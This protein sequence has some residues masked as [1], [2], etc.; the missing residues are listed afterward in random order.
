MNLIGK[1]SI[2]VLLFI[3]FFLFSKPVFG[4]EDVTSSWLETTPLPYTLASHTSIVFDNNILVIGGSAFTGQSRQGLIYSSSLQDG[5]L[6]PWISEGNFP[7]APIWQSTVKDGENIYVLGGREENPGSANDFVS[8]V[9]LGKVQDGELSSWTAQ[10]PLPK[11]LGMGASVISGNKIYFAGGFNN[12]ELSN[13]VYVATIESNGNLGAWTETTP[14][15]V[16]MHG[17]GM[18][19]HNNKVYIFGGYSGVYHSEV[20][21]AFV[22]PDGTLSSWLSE[23]SFPH[24]LYRQSVVK[25]GNQFFSI[26]GADSNGNSTKT[27]YYATINQDGSLAPWELS[28]NELPFSLH[29]ATAVVV[30]NHLYVMGGFQSGG[31]YVNSVY[32]TKLNI[33]PPET[34]LNVPLFMQNDSAWGNHI[35]DSANLWSPSSPGISAWG[36]AMSSAAMVFNYHKIT[37]L[38]N[39]LDLNP[40]N[41]NAW[42]KAQPD[43][44][45]GSGWVNWLALSRL[46]KQ[47][48]PRNPLFTYDALEFNRVIGNNHTQLKADLE[49]SIPGILE[50]PGHFVVGKGTLSDS[51]AINDPYYSDRTTLSFYSN[52]FITL[53]RFIPSNTDLSYIML[54]VDDGIMPLV[55]D[56]GGNI[57]GEGFIQQPLDE[58]EG[59]R[60]SGNSMYMY[61]VSQP[62]SGE[63]TIEIS[64]NK[65]YSLQTFFYDVNGEVKKQTADGVVVNNKKD[66][67]MVIF[68]K[69]NASTSSSKEKV[70]FDNL[71]Y[72]IEYFYSIK[73]IKLKV[74]YLLLREEVEYAKK[75][76]SKNRKLARA[77][78]GLVVSQ[79]DIAKKAAVTEDAYRIL[80]LQAVELY[81]SLK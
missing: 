44:Y 66:S 16:P 5:D 45:V 34:A 48:K 37:K 38:P 10:T 30:N 20:Y 71:L 2:P 3:L 46:S 9:F 31:G 54:I 64:G 43:G 51:F 74:L 70:S 78:M 42:L 77:S 73:K 4:I 50:V 13:K 56:S 68:N 75:I 49:S 27:I 57:I 63:F 32:Y 22:N 33:E 76:S 58:D 15:P 53:N 23:P 60:K 55:K 61:Y 36:C 47:A 62:E 18:L 6:S 67:Y 39:N 29:G 1:L 28:V 24:G 19:E 11:K 14:L 69:Q 21:S 12:N 25:I 8:K 7:T 65:P 80:R 59:S 35:Y 41:L 17:L 26:G 79:L 40:G 72:D 81:N 52:S